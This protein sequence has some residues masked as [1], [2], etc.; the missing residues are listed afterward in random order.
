[1]AHVALYK[2]DGIYFNNIVNTGQLCSLSYVNWNVL[3]D[4]FRQNLHTMFSQN[5]INFF[6]IFYQDVLNRKKITIVVK[7][8]YS[9]NK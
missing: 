1:M 9:K 3:Y 5:K 6:L 2:Y 7:G 8:Y 4:L